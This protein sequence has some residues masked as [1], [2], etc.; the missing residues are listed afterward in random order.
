MGRKGRNPLLRVVPLEELK[1]GVQVQETSRSK[2]FY[3]EDPQVGLL[4]FL[5]LELVSVSW[6]V[7][8]PQAALGGILL[9]RDT[10]GWC[11]GSKKSGKGKLQRLEKFPFWNEGFCYNGT[12]LKNN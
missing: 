6:F 5:P 4:H 7:S 11:R 3:A 1:R 10:F 9:F 12:E 8:A 2:G